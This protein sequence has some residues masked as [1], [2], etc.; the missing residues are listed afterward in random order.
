MTID[1]TV[2]APIVSAVAGVRIVLRSRRQYLAD[3]IER[4]HYY[5]ATSGAL[6]TLAI[7][8]YV[9]VGHPWFAGFLVALVLPE[10]VIPARL[11]PRW[12]AWFM[13][14]IVG[15]KTRMRWEYL[16]EQKA[17]EREAEREFQQRMAQPSELPTPRPPGNS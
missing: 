5:A 4:G 1:W 14:H 6:G 2:L 11:Y 16:R 7:A 12:E 17:M 8:W 9:G 10:A 3:E 15:K 13:R